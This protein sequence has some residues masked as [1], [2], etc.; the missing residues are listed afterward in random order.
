[1]AKARKP[2][3]FGKD[4]PRINRQGRPPV[5]LSLADRVRAVVG[6]DGGKL[7]EMWTAIAY[8][9]IPS[10][11]DTSSSRVAYLAALTEM[12]TKANIAER[13]IASRL[14]AERG[15]GKPKETTEHTGKI[16]VGWEA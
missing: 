15:F 4:D 16:V 11:T 5:G 14:L 9:R 8:G 1:M 6:A 3:A 13:I 12:G 7:V 2:G 10:D